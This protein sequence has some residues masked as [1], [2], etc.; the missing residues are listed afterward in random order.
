MAKEFAIWTGLVTIAVLLAVVGGKRSAS[1]GRA[2]EVPGHEVVGFDVLGGFEYVTPE[3][4]EREPTGQIPDEV[5]ALDQKS[6][7]VR[8]FVLPL[9]SDRGD[10][11]R[12]YLARYPMGCCF[13]KPVAAN[14]LVLVDLKDPVPYRPHRPLWLRGRLGVEEKFDAA[15]YLES[16][17]RLEDGA[18]VSMEERPTAH[19]AAASQ[20]GLTPAGRPIRGAKFPAASETGG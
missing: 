1:A 16:V 3:V 19:E 8:G 20:S 4:G 7:L 2:P 18:L 15:G 14:E 5:A 10:V 12:F 11:F 17:Y 13:G 9:E 6:V